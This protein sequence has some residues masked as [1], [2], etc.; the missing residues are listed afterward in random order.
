MPVSDVAPVLEL[1]GIHKEFPGVKALSDAGLR[2]FPARC[3][4]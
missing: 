1:T 4:R 2:L 3:I